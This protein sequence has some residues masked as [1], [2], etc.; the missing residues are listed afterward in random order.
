MPSLISADFDLTARHDEQ[1]AV[2]RVRA[3]DA[4]ALEVI[5]VG[6]RAELLAEALRVTRSAALA[7]EV[8]QDV[9]LAI[10]TG[11]AR[12]HVATSLGAY[13]HRAVHNVASRTA[14]SRSRGL[15]AGVELDAAAARA[16]TL[17]RDPDPAPDVRAE[18]AELADAITAAKDEMPLRAREVYVLS[19]END[20]TNREIADSLGLSVKTVESHMKRARDV[21]R[22]KLSRWRRLD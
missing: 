11:R 3:G 13:L 5:F 19:R 20:L 1:L 14:A 15:S 7:E 9:F 2:E 21:L 12:W 16:P 6:Y 18:R 17:F 10:W 22:S 8:V 4:L